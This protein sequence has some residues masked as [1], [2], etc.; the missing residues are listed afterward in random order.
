LHGVPDL[1][2]L[3]TYETHKRKT[4]TEGKIGNFGVKHLRIVSQLQHITQKSN[5]L[6]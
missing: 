6:I 2:E 5:L 1:S 3:S 4:G